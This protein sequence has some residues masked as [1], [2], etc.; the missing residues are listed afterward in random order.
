MV[1]NEGERGEVHFVSYKVL[2][3]LVAMFAF[4]NELLVKHIVEKTWKHK[5][6]NKYIKIVGDKNPKHW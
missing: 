3:T 2:G 4:E 1:V 6:I 5:F